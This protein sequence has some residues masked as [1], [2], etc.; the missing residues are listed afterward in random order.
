MPNEIRVKPP[1]RSAAS[2]CSVTVSGLASAVT[3]APGARPNSAS[4]ARRIAASWPGGSSVGVPPPKNT[5]LTG[6]SA[7]PSTCLASRISSIARP[8]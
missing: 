7:S 8:A 6:M 5:V 1:P 3:S 2:V 4:I